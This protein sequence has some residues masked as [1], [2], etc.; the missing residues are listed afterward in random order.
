M[1]ITFT[2]DAVRLGVTTRMTARCSQG[3]GPR[4]RRW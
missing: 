4:A 2:T 3:H 1:T